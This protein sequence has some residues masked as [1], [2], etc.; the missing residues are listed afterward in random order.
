MDGMDLKPLLRALGRAVVVGSL[1]VLV[2]TL[3][4]AV[5]LVGGATAAAHLARRR[6]EDP[7][8]EELD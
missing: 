1:A 6:G 4:V 7:G 3:A 5:V 2:V 8:A